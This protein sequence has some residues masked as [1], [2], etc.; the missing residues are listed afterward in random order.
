MDKS[1]VIILFTNH[2]FYIFYRTIQAAKPTF[3][4]LIPINS[5]YSMYA[6]QTPIAYCNVHYVRGRFIQ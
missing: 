1:S 3:L 5:G 4:F 6:S 2:F